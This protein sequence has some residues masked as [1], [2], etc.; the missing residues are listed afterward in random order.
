MMMV[1]AGIIVQKPTIHCA[2]WRGHI[3]DIF[4]CRKA[5]R[6]QVWYG[7]GI[8]KVHDL[9]NYVLWEVYP[10]TQSLTSLPQKSLVLETR[11][12]CPTRSSCHSSSSCTCYTWSGRHVSPSHCGTPNRTSDRTYKSYLHT[13]KHVH[14]THMHFI[15]KVNVRTCKSNILHITNFSYIDIPHF[16]LWKLYKMDKFEW[17]FVSPVAREHFRHFYLSIEPYENMMLVCD[18]PH[19]KVHKRCIRTCRLSL[20]YQ[21]RWLYSHNLCWDTIS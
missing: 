10:L 3:T 5:T 2:I 7:Y 13:Y 21:C 12:G 14:I 11:Q 15:L 6:Y 8:G 4:S 1:V 19:Y 18:L 20:H 9:H 16:S 17:F